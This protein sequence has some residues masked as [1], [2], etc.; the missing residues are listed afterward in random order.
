MSW[1]CSQK[2]SWGKYCFVSA[3]KVH[4]FAKKRVCG[5]DRAKTGRQENTDDL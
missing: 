1:K 4:H 3:L 5:K 2:Y